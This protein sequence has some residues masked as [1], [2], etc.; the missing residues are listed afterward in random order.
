MHHFNLKSLA[1]YGVAIGSVLLLFK[2]ITVYGENNLKAP[3]ALSV[4][5]RLVLSESLPDCAKSDALMLHLQQSGVYLNASLAPTGGN[6]TSSVI[7]NQ[8]PLTGTLTNDSLNLTGKVHHDV[9]C[10]YPVAAAAAS[11][12]SQNNLNSVKIEIKLAQGDTHQGEITVNDMSHAIGF[13]AQAQKAGKQ[14]EN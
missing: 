5:Y 1:F 10:N 12:N 4:K 8:A 7:E 6:A 3:R 2:V 9:L 14:S 11:P 13:T